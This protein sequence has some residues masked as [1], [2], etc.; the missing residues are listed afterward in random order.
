MVKMGKNGDIMNDDNVTTIVGIGLESGYI[1]KGEDLVDAMK[2][3]FG[4]R[5][6]ETYNVDIILEL[7]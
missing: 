7:I 6:S 5:E 1:W 2:E 4:I 3:I